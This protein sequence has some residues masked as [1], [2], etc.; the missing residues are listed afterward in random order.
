M[1][2]EKGVETENHRRTRRWQDVKEKI[3]MEKHTTKTP[4]KHT[5]NL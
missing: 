4:A 3:E 2:Q 1:E 5:R